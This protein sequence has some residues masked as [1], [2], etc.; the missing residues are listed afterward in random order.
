LPEQLFS[1]FLDV[2]CIADA[3]SEGFEDD[4][5]QGSFAGDQGALRHVLAVKVDQI[6][7]IEGDGASVVS[8]TQSIERGLASLIETTIS[9]S[10]IAVLALMSFEISWSSGNFAV[11]LRLLREIKRT[12]PSLKKQSA[13]NPSHFGSNSHCGSEK[14]SFTAV[15]NI[16]SREGGMESSLAAEGRLSLSA[17]LFGEDFSF[18]ASHRS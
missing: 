12:L 14:G 6:E 8:I 2:L 10:I 11:R 5:F 13:R 17:F 9:P 4:A 7:S 18:L 1:L 15:G 3:S 16:G